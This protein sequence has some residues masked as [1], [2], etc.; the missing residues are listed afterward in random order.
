MSSARDIQDQPALKDVCADDFR[1]GVALSESQVDGDEPEST[2]LVERHFN[3]I[4]PENILKWE[5]VHPEPDV[6][7]FEPVDRLVAFAEQRGMHLVGHTFVWFFQID[8]LINPSRT[9]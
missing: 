4:V 1:V 3:S 9:T 7:N 2:A 6:Y 8:A 5:A